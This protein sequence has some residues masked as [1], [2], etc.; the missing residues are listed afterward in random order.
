VEDE[1]E[2]GRGPADEESGAGTGV[3]RSY[4]RG[5]GFDVGPPEGVAA[6]V[7]VG[8]TGPVAVGGRNGISIG[9]G[10]S[11]PVISLLPAVSTAR[12]GTEASPTRIATIST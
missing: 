8:S 3:L 6:R 7:G 9:R 4:P 1:S 10:W 12:V 2:V 11:W 5:V